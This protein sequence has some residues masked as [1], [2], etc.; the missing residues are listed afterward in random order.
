VSLINTDVPPRLRGDPG[1]LRQ[2]ITNLLVNAIKFTEQG[3]VIVRVIR[4]SE[5]ETHVDLC[6]TVSDSGIGIPEEALPYL[7]QAFSQVDGSTTRKYGGT[8]LG[9]A[10]S[11]QLVEIMGGQIGVESTPGRGSTFWFTVRLEKL[12]SAPASPS[13]SRP[14]FAGLRVLA[15]DDNEPSSRVLLQ[16]AAMLGLRMET[17]ESGHA[18]LQALQQAAR[19]GQPFVVAILDMQMPDADG[20]ALAQAIRANPEIAAT[21]LLMMTSRSPQND[22]AILRAAGVGAFLVKPIRQ[23]QL[24]DCLN[25]VLTET[26]QH[27][28]RYWLDDKKM[29]PGR[30]PLPHRPPTERTVHVLVAEDNPINQRVAVALLEKLG[31]QAQAVATGLEVL[32]ALEKVAYEIILMD[33]QLPELDGFETTREIR[34]REQQASESHVRR[35]H[36]IAMTAYALR[37]AREECLAAGMDDYISKPVHIEALVGA[38]R[39]ALGT[40]SGETT[41]RPDTPASLPVPSAVDPDA[42]QVLRSLRQPDKPDPFAELIEMFLRDTP[43]NLEQMELAVVRYDPSTLA[44][45]AHNLRGCASTI[46]ARQLS[47]LCGELENLARAGALQAAAN[48]MRRLREEYSRVEVALQRAGST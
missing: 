42:L 11:K 35:V 41:H 26:T 18:A 3:E 48:A 23:K 29:A 37:G 38:L 13:A 33:C 22:T 19:V 17:V 14:G 47:A 21:R 9:L 24:V 20:L 5:S 36:I 28:T 15:A 31:Y 6:F 34:R 43:K 39:R 2:I 12:P 27:E 25:S 32:R 40:P 1:R 8:G 10:I 46:G 7:F 45:C 30:V 16:H 4:E 44:A